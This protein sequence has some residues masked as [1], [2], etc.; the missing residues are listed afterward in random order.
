[1]HLFFPQAH[2]NRRN[3]NNNN[4]NNN[5]KSHTEV[6][7]ADPVIGRCLLNAR[8]EVIINNGHDENHCVRSLNGGTSVV[9]PFNSITL[10]E[11]P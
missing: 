6:P 11:C 7:K 9:T 10:D 3:R 1:M 2:G 4:N 8:E 5:D